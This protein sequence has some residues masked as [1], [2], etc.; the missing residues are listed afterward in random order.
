MFVKNDASHALVFA[1]N[2]RREVGRLLPRLLLRG[3]SFETVYEV[4]ELCPGKL[5]RNIDTGAIMLDPR[6]VYQYGENK[7]LL[8]SGRTLCCAGLPVKFLFDADSVLFE[9]KAVVNTLSL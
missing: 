2:I 8:L 3:L 1:F 9:L 6:G 7:K 4:E 5:V